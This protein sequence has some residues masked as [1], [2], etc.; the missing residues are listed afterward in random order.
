MQDRTRLTQMS[1]IEE[2]DGF[3][4]FNFPSIR[5]QKGKGTGVCTERASIA[6]NLWLLTG[7]QSYFFTSKDCRFVDGEN[8]GHSFSVVKLKK[9]FRLC[10]FALDRFD[11]FDNS[12]IDMINKKQPLLFGNNVYF[13][14]E[15]DCAGELD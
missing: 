2:D 12:P 11:L 8:A 15:W 3:D 4:D 10:D 1:I 7:R 13:G 14:T 5:V 9:G 6:H